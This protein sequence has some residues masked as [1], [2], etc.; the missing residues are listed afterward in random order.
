MTTYAEINLQARPY[1][2]PL[3][4][5]MRTGLCLFS[6]GFLG[7]NDAIHFCRRGIC[8]TCVDTDAWK[9]REMETMYP[10]AWTF[11]VEDAWE[12]ALDAKGQT[13]DV[14]SI[15]PFVGD[16]CDRVWCSRELFLGLARKLVTLTIPRGMEVP[17][18]AGWSS[19][20]FP[21]GTETVADWLV[22]QRA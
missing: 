17:E 19:S 20:V 3:L 4:K 7:W 10:D 21:R 2:S 6:A 16:I 8:T 1:P 11:V 18:I 15:D 5:G 22:L 13:W 9:T 12:F 14:V